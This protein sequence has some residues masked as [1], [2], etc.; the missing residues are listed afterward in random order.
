V[1][2]A[3]ELPLHAL[4]RATDVALAHSS[5]VV[6][7]AAAFGVPSVVTSDYGAEL[8]ANLLQGGQALLATDDAAIADAVVQL[9]RR[10][11]EMPRSAPLPA[12]GL[13]HA[14]DA[15]AVAPGA[16]ARG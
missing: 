14:L 15:W 3:T 10:R 7:E 11:R 5:T 4:L 13:A 1:Q 8:H 16:G 12:D 6:Q 2:Q 9:A